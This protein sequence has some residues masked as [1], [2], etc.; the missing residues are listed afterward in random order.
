MKPIADFFTFISIVIGGVVLEVVILHTFF[1]LTKRKAE[2]KKFSV[3]RYL[4]LLS[5]PLLATYIL[6]FRTDERLLKVFIFF[7][8]FGAVI[9]WL[10]GFFYHKVVGQ[11][12]WTYHYFPWFN[13]YTSWMS[14]PLWGLAG[15]MFWLAARMF[16]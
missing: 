5:F 12:L 6:F 14:M 10:V 8:I 7:S 9:E 1:F 13:S 2:T 15:V 3:I 16:V 11:K 4:Y